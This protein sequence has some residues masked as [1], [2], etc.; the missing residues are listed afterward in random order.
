MHRDYLWV[1]ILSYFPLLLCNENPRVEKLDDARILLIQ[2]SSH[3][4]LVEQELAN[5]DL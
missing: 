5:V 3:L 4:A 2:L 1:C